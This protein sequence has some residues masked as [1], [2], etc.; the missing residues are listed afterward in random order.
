M[1]LPDTVIVPAV[2]DAT[3]PADTVGAT[4]WVF[5]TVA[6]IR[7]LELTLTVGFAVMV[8]LGVFADPDA[9]DTDS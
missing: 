2:P 3:Y 9:T 6:V 7:P 1:P 4:D 5:D 8:V